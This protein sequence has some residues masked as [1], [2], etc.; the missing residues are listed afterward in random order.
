M[1]K[2]IGLIVAIVVMLFSLASCGKTCYNCGESIEG[3]SYTVFGNEYCRD[4]FL[5]DM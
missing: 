2:K 1:K 3:K 5:N 4:C